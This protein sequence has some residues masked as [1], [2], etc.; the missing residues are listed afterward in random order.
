MLFSTFFGLFSCQKRKGRI[1]NNNEAFQPLQECRKCSVLDIRH[2][3][4]PFLWRK[5][6]HIFSVANN[7][8]KFTTVCKFQDFCITE[9][10]RE[11]NFVDLRGCEFY[12]LGKFQPSKS[13]KIHKNLNSEP[14]NFVKWLILHF[15]NPQN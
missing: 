8:I 1:H 11:I 14:L 9:I 15:K 6:C 3:I 5:K 13:A 7:N 12:S 4:S 2:Q 10:L